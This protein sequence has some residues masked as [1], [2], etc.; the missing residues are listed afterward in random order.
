MGSIPKLSVLL[1]LIFKLKMFE[2]VVDS[3]S[4]ENFFTCQFFLS[5]MH[6]IFVLSLLRFL[7]NFQGSFG[8]L[9]KMSEDVPT[10][11][12]HFWHYK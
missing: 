8:T 11:F 9:P 10:T 6:E 7:S 2:E 1:I 4:K 12:E 5:N 3:N